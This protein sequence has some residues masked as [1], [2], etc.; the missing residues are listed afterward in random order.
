MSEHEERQSEAAL[1]QRLKKALE[2]SP[3]SP[4]EIDAAIRQA[5]L[6]VGAEIRTRRIGGRWP[7]AAASFLLGAV[8]SGAVFAWRPLPWPREPLVVPIEV[9]LRGAETA[10]RSVP[11]E[12][13]DP[14]V[15]YDYIE[16]LVYTGQLGRLQ[17]VT[18][19]DS[20]SSIRAIVRRLECGVTA[21]KYSCPSVCLGAAVDDCRCV[22]GLLRGARRRRIIAARGF[23]VDAT[24][25]RRPSAG[26][27]RTRRR[28][29]CPR[30]ACG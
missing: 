14:Q 30:P 5:A 21:M 16:E 24:S 12:S 18:C 4:K 7:A 15:W 8:L 29:L 3:G 1:G 10:S 28:A 22:C 2:A 26:T 6:N 25:G 11:V 9:A 17:S 13:A 20:T 27:V 23:S 19:I